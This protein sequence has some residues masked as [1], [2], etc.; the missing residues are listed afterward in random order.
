[1]TDAGLTVV[2]SLISPFRSG[3]AMARS[4]FA[5]EE[6]WEIHVDAPLAIVERRDPKGLY[7]KARRGELRDFTGIDSPYEPPENPELRID[8]TA[9]SPEDGAMA[10]ISRMQQQGLL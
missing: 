10:V 1:M 7:A 9:S 8:T 5:A 6:F 4:R 3:R 2:V